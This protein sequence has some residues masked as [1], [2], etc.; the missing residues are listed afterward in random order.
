L[1][2][3]HICK[4]MC[5]EC[6]EKCAPCIEKVE[7]Q[8]PQCGHFRQM[9]CSQPC[10]SYYCLVQVEKDLPCGHKVLEDCHKN[11][12]IILCPELCKTLLEC[13]HECKGTCGRCQQGRFHTGCESDC[14][15]TLLCGRTFDSPS[16]K[17]PPYLHHYSLH[18]KFPGSCYERVNKWDFSQHMSISTIIMWQC[19]IPNKWL[20][21]N[22]LWYLWLLIP[23]QAISRWSM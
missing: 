2:C 16:A 8:V 10:D 9:L 18:N 1:P 5:Y 13:E 23:Y 15:Q 11:V 21:R 22:V 14:G 12:K 3:H 4:R 19:Q 7:K 6:S 20:T 17:F